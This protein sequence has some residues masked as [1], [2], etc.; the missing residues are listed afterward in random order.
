MKAVEIEYFSLLR[1]QSGRPRETLR[2]RANTPRELYA[3]LCDRYDFSLSMDRLRVAINDEFCDWECQLDDGAR[4][5]FIP[6][7]AGG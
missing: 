1:E 6:P 4:V 5:V 3:Q 7:V 2:T